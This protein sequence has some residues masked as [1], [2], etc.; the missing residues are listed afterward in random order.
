MSDDNKRLLWCLFFCVNSAI[1]V[2]SATDS[3]AWMGAVLSGEIAVIWAIL[4]TGESVKTTN[5]PT[6]ITGETSVTIHSRK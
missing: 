1:C 2:W 4:P 6:S 3:L 5:Y